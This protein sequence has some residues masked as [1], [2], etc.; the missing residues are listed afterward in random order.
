[1][2]NDLSRSR[3]A[4]ARGWRIGRRD[5]R[6]RP[7]WWLHPRYALLFL[8][9]PL[10]VGSYLIP[11]YTYLTLYGT[12]KHIDLDYVVLGSLVYLAFIAGSF[13]TVGTN[14]R[15]Q[16]RDIIAYCRWVIWPLFGL[17][18][19]GYVVWFSAAMLRAGGPGALLNAF[20]GLV[21]D[22]DF[23]ASESVK[24]DLFDTIPGITT[25][26]QL[27][28]AYVTVEALLWVRKKSRRRLAALRFAVLASF[29]LP[30]AILIS[31][32]LAL[33]EIAVPIIVVLVSGLR[34]KGAYRGLVRWAPVYLVGGVFGLF[35]LGEYF[36]SW[37][38]Y[39]PNYGG[40][41]LRFAVERFLGYYA[42]AINNGAVIYYYEPLQPMIHT[43]N[44]LFVFPILG[45]EVS[46]V[47]N[48]IF[49]VPADRSVYLLDTYANPEF[50]NAAL[51][52]LLLNEYSVFL[53]PVAA[54]VMGVIAVSLYRDFARGRLVGA[55]LYPSWFIGVLE[56]SR[57]YF[58]SDQRYFPTLAFFIISLLLFRAAKVPVNKPLP[59]G[60]SPSMPRMAERR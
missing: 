23:S 14:T 38:F 42:T 10:L 20:V 34:L 57:I 7:T 11:E 56:I 33:I 19:F 47:Y 6:R 4:S 21:L 52:G 13:F 45:V 60:P 16:Q 59:R 2:G 24:F 39:Q 18:I 36:R 40:P 9:I 41:Y 26:T 17:T 1:M 5:G 25:L 46:E 12:E 54:F 51:V 50:N 8:G 49:G 3:T 35:A 32:R 28:V 29:L 58:W 15:S 48:E 30:R 31:E 22:P 27:G 53:A 37:A 43:L 55:V 44:S